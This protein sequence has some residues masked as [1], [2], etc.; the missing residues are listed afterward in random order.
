MKSLEKGEHF[1]FGE[2]SNFWRWSLVKRKTLKYLQN[3]LGR[4]VTGSTVSKIK[5]DGDKETC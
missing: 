4:P 3:S 2:G 1:S 5:P